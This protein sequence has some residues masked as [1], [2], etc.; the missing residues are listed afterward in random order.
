MGDNKFHQNKKLERK[1]KEKM[2]N[3]VHVII[4]L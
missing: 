4:S 3:Q 2:K 1:E